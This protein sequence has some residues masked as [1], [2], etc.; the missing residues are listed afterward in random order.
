MIPYEV[1]KYLG[2]PN[3]QVQD[4]LY[5]I[6]PEDAVENAGVLNWI[7]ENQAR[8]V[9]SYFV[10]GKHILQV[11]QLGLKILNS[12]SIDAAIN[13][14]GILK[15]M[16]VN[17]GVVVNTSVLDSDVPVSYCDNCTVTELI[18]G[19]EVTRQKTVRELM[20]CI[21]G[22]EGNSVILCA[23]RKSIGGNGSGLVHEEFLRF[24]NQFT[25]YQVFTD[26]QLQS[27]KDSNIITGE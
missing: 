4:Y 12:S 11:N 9:L 5:I 2:T 1:R 20:I 23:E 3:V 6:L 7:Q 16:K 19:Q 25:N 10:D 17:I 27:W 24:K 14:G 18:D 8:A 26:A 22:T 13:A 21:E 15:S